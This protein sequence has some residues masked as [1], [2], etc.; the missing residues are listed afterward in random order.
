VQ[1]DPAAVALD[2]FGRSSEYTYTALSELCGIPASNLCHR[3]NGRMSIKQRAINQQY[4]SPRTY[5][6]DEATVPESGGS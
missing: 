1:I 6:Q 5:E 2:R 3:K 4:L